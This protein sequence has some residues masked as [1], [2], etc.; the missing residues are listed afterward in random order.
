MIYGG[1]KM[2]NLSLYNITNKF[3]E[4][5]DKAQEGELTE[6]EYNQ[7]GEEL[8]IELQNKS[9]GI[10]GYTQNEEA[11]IE[12]IDI[13]IKRLQELKKAKQNNLDK[14]KQYVKDNMD[15]LSITKLETELGTLSIAKNPMSIEIQNED[16]IPSEFKQQIITT[17]VDKTAIKN[18]FKETGEII[19]GVNIVDDKTSLRIK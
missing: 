3:V 13:Q 11:L 5:M 1:K 16:E 14:F 4:L 7:L 8:A 6:E 10:I 2:S 9:A 19:P 15:R 18:H 12:A 17:K